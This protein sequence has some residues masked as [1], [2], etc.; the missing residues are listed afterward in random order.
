MKY[1]VQ[2]V[3][4]K[5]SCPAYQDIRNRHYIPNH[6]AIGQQL[7]YLI[8][9]DNEIVG[10]ISG[11][12]S[13]Y[14]VKSRDEYFGIT[15]EN[16]IIDNT[17]FRL[18]KN[19]PNLGTQ[20][21]A[22][23][24]KQVAE[25]WYRKYQVRPC[26]FETFIIENGQ[27]KGAMYKADN[28]DCVGETYGSAKF[29]GNGINRKGERVTTGSKMIFCKRIKGAELPEDYYPVWKNAN[30]ARGQITMDDLLNQHERTTLP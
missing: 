20:I 15:K 18:E 21:L 22:M 9:L 7:H 5:R 1:N 13:A 16:G 8:Y 12:A 27:R 11:G 4:C 25:D 10:I 30:M 3:P 6:G 14:S 19:L 17:V 2:L 26:G 28:W 24:R 23:W 29:H